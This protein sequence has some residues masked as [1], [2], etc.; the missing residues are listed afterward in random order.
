[1]GET[2]NKNVNTNKAH[3]ND[4][5]PK[6]FRWNYLDELMR[7][8]PGKDGPGANIKDE[9]FDTVTT[10]FID[11]SK[12]MNVGYYS[13]L[14]SYTGNDAMGEQQ[15]MR[16]FSDVNMF[17]ALTNH[18]NVASVK[19]C[20]DKKQKCWEQRWTWAIPLE[21]IYMTPLEN[22]NPCNLEFIE[23]KKDFEKAQNAE[24][25]TGKID[26]PIRGYTER[27]YWQKVPSKFF[28]GKN[29]RDLADTGAG[30]YAEG[31]DSTG[32]SL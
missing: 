6:N 30:Y 17:A 1:M 32:K 5:Y 12:E 19:V 25:R 20:T 7:Q 15:D 4:N 27:D 3:R 16:G 8:I 14:Y 18:K 11:K 2:W 21:I 22:W 28:K 9:S 10:E 29:G 23:K 24:G 13:R 26:H 31:K